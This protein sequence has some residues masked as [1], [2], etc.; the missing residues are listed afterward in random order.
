MRKKTVEVLFVIIGVLLIAY[1]IVSNYL[2]TYHRTYVLSNYEEETGKLSDEER[3]ALLEEA[4]NY[5]KEVSLETTVDISLNSSEEKKKVSYYNVL[6]VGEAMAYITIPKINVYL[7]IY[8]GISDNV[9]QSGVGHIENTSLPIGGPGTHCVLPGHT[10]LSRTKMFD[11]INKLELGDK[12]YITVLGKKLVYEV[13]K[14]IV[15]EPDNKDA[16]KIE[17]NKD[18]VTLLTCTP[19]MIN[20]HRLLVRGV[21]VSDAALENESEVKI[22]T[23]KMQKSN[24]MHIAFSIVFFSILLII[25][26]FY[27]LYYREKKEEQRYYEEEK[28]ARRTKEKR[29]DRNYN[30]FIPVAKEDEDEKEEEE[31]KNPYYHELEEYK[32]IKNRLNLDND[33][34]GKKKEKNT[35]DER[36]STYSRGTSRVVNKKR[37]NKR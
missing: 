37:R 2:A 31:P 34:S 25:L 32:K 6:N 22:D 23:V 17:P 33:Y 35:K 5:N 8:H 29:R 3:D 4:Q 10:G 11:D 20:T 21:R 30:E 36:R 9:L 18:Y 28:V 16:I 24:V 14:I 13:D 26:L 1:P 15:V 12:F 19:Y 27:I 7:P